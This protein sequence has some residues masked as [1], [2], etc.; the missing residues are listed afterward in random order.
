MSVDQ[1][2]MEQVEIRLGRQFGLLLYAVLLSFAL[3]LALAVGWGSRNYITN[4]LI[5][6]QQ[7]ISK[8]F[9]QELLEL[10]H[11]YRNSLRQ[12]ASTPG[13]PQ[14]A[15]ALAKGPFFVFRGE[16]IGEKLDEHEAIPLLENQIWFLD[17]IIALAKQNELDYVGLYL[18]SP[19]AS[20]P[21]I[22]ATP[23]AEI[24]D[25]KLTLP[26]FKVKGQYQNLPQFGYR[27]GLNP[28][29][30]ASILH[31]IS[32]MASEARGVRE[33]KNA[34][35]VYPAL[36]LLPM[37]PIPA[38]K[39]GRPGIEWL[40]HA[41]GL[42]VRLTE[43][44]VATNFNLKTGN[45]EP[46]RVALLVYEKELSAPVLNKMHIKYGQQLAILSDRRFVSASLP[47]LMGRELR[48]Q[49]IVLSDGHEY[50]PLVSPLVIDG[51]GNHFSVAILSDT[52]KIDAISWTIYRYVAFSTVAV[53]ILI[54]P[55][56][57]GVLNRYTRKVRQ[58]TTLLRKQNS[59]LDRLS[60]EAE[61]AR[62]RL[63]DMTER[64]PLTV[65]QLRITP[66]GRKRY[67]FVGKNVDQVMGVDALEMM[68]DPELRWANVVEEER[69]ASRALIEQAIHQHTPIE[70]HQRV[71]L[72]GQIRTILVHTVPS[73]L[74]DGSW[75]WN[76][77]YMDVTEQ[78]A[79]AE[80]LR[81]A[82]ELAEQATLTKSA[83]LANMSH[84]IR[85]PMNAIMG[86]SRLM[87]K[88]VLSE[89]QRD[90]I[91]KIFSASDT[92][93][94]IINDILDFSK[95]EA[96]QLQL[97]MTP[98]ALH[99][100][101]SGLT[102]T[103]AL[104]AQAKGLEFLFEIEP[105]VPRILLGDPLRLGQIMINLANNA[106][107]FTE[108]GEIVVAIRCPQ[109]DADRASLIIS[110]SDT[111]LGIKPEQLATL[112]RPFTQADASITRKYGGTGLGLA[113]CKQLA[114]LMGGQ[115]SAH[116]TP[117]R[118]SEFSLSL[119]LGKDPQQVATPL[120][121]IP[122]WQQQA[123]L[124]VD[125]NAQARRILADM[126]GQMGM[127]VDTLASGQAAIS[128]LVVPERQVRHHLLLIDSA[129]PGMDGL[130]TVRQIRR[131]RTQDAGPPLVIILL[132]G[133]YDD[134]DLLA[135]AQ[136]AGVNHVLAKPVTEAGLH[137]A[138]LQALHHALNQ[139]ST[140]ARS[141]P[142]A[143]S[144]APSAHPAL[145]SL[146]A[147][148]GRYQAQPMQTTHGSAAPVLP[149][150]LRGARVLLVEDS[151]LNQQV[152]SEFL[153][154]MG[155][156]VHLANNGVEGVEKVRAE[157]WDL[158][159][160]DI[161]M[162]E[163]DGL[164][165]TRVIRSEPRLARLPII[166]MTAHAMSGDRELSLAAGMN[167]HITKPIDPEQLYR[168]LLRWLRQQPTAAPVT[169]ALTPHAQDKQDQAANSA[170]G[171]GLPAALQHLAAN[172]IDV[173]EGLARHLNRTS[174]YQR[175]LRMFIREHGDSGSRLQ[176]LLA[177]NDRTAVRRLAHNLKAGAGTIAATHLTGLAL[178]LEQAA[179]QALPGG[180]EVQALQAELAR[181]CALLRQFDEPSGE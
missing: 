111:G 16:Q 115:L 79:R 175:V 174:F 133:S 72:H 148:P 48:Q 138:L 114:D 84:E 27:F 136:Q 75:I 124:V 80:E 162:P 13:N 71:W 1:E 34:G 56:L 81:Q 91:S 177:N 163:M 40:P 106:V 88:T 28:G 135:L 117:R 157:A 51:T 23:A 42:T 47:Q 134:G 127:Q 70:M 22:P 96:G 90:Y 2:S 78:Q 98:F 17:N 167:D 41:H 59:K 113:I 32:A 129:M 155:I 11:N 43:E 57:Y 105:A 95:V 122:G 21:G 55:V 66:D 7:A 169:P 104:K 60:A 69:E 130:A 62:Q 76:G 144:A 128:T 54:A 149:G 36:G 181:V 166:A 3:I 107:K 73:A 35:E 156:L 165:A 151:P 50:L 171:S 168:T 160:M 5:E 64:L 65:V 178:A 179:E 31:Q 116:S 39:I 146:S 9:Q 158:V 102:N 142:S 37:T 150:A 52:N 103:V 18:V 100:L 38:R 118:G 125:D 159:L 77:F 170:P 97:E 6:E 63:L 101:Q 8:L 89:Q 53:L 49:R 123:A 74:A 131:M 45:H 137:Q 164:A 93:L 87:Q 86:L 67:V 68:R 25:G 121:P 24:A 58:R 154:E 29:Q 20:I 140:S 33:A 15:L 99:D 126:L 145:P 141:A 108:R 14:R 85:T 19:H 82:K 112:F 120:P 46:T 147:L 61:T 153:Q 139:P 119:T 132:A 94:H 143:P 30:D 110:I 180:D 83:F 173:Q 161:Q 176:D 26:L 92:L 109:Q 12:F 172:G 10:T 152:A 44:I 4:G